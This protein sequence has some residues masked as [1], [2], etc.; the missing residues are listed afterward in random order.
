MPLDENH[1]APGARRPR[2]RF[3]LLSQTGLKGEA[4]FPAC[5]STE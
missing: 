1:R 5:V 4:A 2:Q 3:W